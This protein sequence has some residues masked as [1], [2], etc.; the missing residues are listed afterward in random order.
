[1]S[2]QEG[3]EYVLQ[4]AREQDV[5]FIRTWFTD[6]L[7]NLKSVAITS[8]ELEKALEEGVGFDGSSIEGFARID[9][10]DM[11]AMP[12]PNT[13]VVLPWRPR[14]RKRVARIFCDILLPDGSPFEGDPRYILK[15]N[16]KRAADLGF[17]FYVG[18]ELEYFYFADSDGTTTLDRGG[19]FDLT[20][21]DAATDLRRETVLALEEMGIAVE[22]SHHEVAPS[23]HEID[24]RY[25]DA[26]TMADNTMTYRLVVKEVALAQ[27]VYAT[28]M[29]KPLANENGSGMHVHQSLF[30]GERNAFFDPQDKPHLSALC[31]S[32]IAG[33]LHHAREITIVTNQWVNSYKRLVP[34]Y[35]APVYLSWALRNRSDL[36]RVPEYKP[37][38]EQDTRIEYRAPDPACNPY[39]AFAAM[40]AAG[41][42]GIEKEYPCPEPVEENV[43]LMT[44]EEKKRRGIEHLPGSLFEAIQAAEKSDMLRRCLGDHVFESLLKNKLIEWSDYRRHVTDYEI[45][46]YLPIL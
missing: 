17:T 4:V 14:E 5:K 18:P 12:D 26:L 32:Y 43:F 35:E 45:K 38:K 24:L 37:G 20:P 40:L 44:E 42:Q 28:F 7:G 15:R 9:E 29:P 46:R 30:R 10:S 25:A 11:V 22:A 36:I 39:L 16:L 34:G 33:L 2:N 8:E 21:L 3:K 41:L 1:M 23:Q 31:K 19:Y 27:G 13:F 6:I